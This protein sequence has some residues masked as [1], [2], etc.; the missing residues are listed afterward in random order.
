MKNQSKDEKNR[1]EQFVLILSLF[2]LNENN[3]AR[4]QSGKNPIFKV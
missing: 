3:V 4:G 2:H 1:Q